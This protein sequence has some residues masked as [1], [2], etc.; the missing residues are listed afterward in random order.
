M[1]SSFNLSGVVAALAIV[2]STT[3]HAQQPLVLKFGTFLGPRHPAVKMFKTN[4]EQVD[5]DTGGRVQVRVYDSGTLAGGPQTLDAVQKGVMDIGFYVWTY[6][7]LG[8]LPLLTIGGLPY[9]Y[10]DGQGYV[11]AWTKD[12][13][14][15]NAVNKQVAE[16]G[17]TNTFF[18]A[19][20]FSG[21][22][23]M[24]FRGHEPKVPADIKGLKIRGTGTY[25]D[26]T[27]A[28]GAVAVTIQTPEV[29]NA[30]QSGLIDGAVGLASNWINFRWK[31]PAGYLLDFRIAPV[32][33]ALAVNKATWSKLSDKDKSALK[34]MFDADQAGM[35]KY[36][37]KLESDQMELVKGD[38]KIYVPT[39]EQLKLW[40]QPKKHIM[41]QWLKAAGPD[42]GKALIAVVEKY[43]K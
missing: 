20:Y 35:N 34:K 30:L 6:A 14:L 1:K 39:D 21:F 40:R 29:Y 11:D 22:A 37:V 16:R 4:A 18:V 25:N 24:G 28:Y 5:K 41:D 26:V 10:R 27:K 17:Y 43:N 38:M 2:A 33:G 15:L 12:D 9:I 8:Q 23:R 36:Y 42:A 13:T 19:P 3:A 31:E 32:G 7:P